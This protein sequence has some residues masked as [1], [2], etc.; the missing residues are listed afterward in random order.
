[1][2]TIADHT[3]PA[4]FQWNFGNILAVVSLALVALGIIFALTFNGVS[5]IRIDSLQRD[6][7]GVPKSVA[8]TQAEVLIIRQ[9][10]GYMQGDIADIRSELA[11]MRSEL[12]GM[13]SDIAYIKEVLARIEAAQQ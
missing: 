8:D 5:A 13:R 2:T 7:A 6:V 10:I 11:G 3:H 12:T 9:D 4:Q 1:M